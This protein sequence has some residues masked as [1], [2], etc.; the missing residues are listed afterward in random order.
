M[1]RDRDTLVPKPFE[2]ARVA[3][4]PVRVPMQPV[5]PRSVRKNI[6]E[7]PKAPPLPEGK[8]VRDPSPTPPVNLCERDER[9]EQRTGQGGPHGKGRSKGS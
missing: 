7:R 8:L 4:D 1:G 6:H 2:P 9:S 5:P 3:H